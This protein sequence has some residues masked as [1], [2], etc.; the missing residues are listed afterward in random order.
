LYARH[1][2]AALA[3]AR[4]LAGSPEHSEDLVQEAFAAVL[5]AIRNGAGPQDS[6]RAYLVTAVRHQHY[7]TSKRARR[8][9][10]TADIE[11]LDRPADGLADP[12][13][14]AQSA[15]DSQLI[16]SA[17]RSLPARWQR[18]LWSTEVEEQSP[19]ELAGELGVSANSAAAL[20]YRARKALAQAYLKAHVDVGVPADC[21]PVAS[22]LAGWVRG[23]L[24]PRQAAAVTAHV[25]DCQSCEAISADLAVVNTSLRAVAPLLLVLPALAGYAAAGNAAASLGAGPPGSS[26]SPIGS[27]SARLGQLSTPARVGIAAGV[28]GPILVGAA[29]AVAVLLGESPQRPVAAAPAQSA[30]APTDEPFAPVVTATA[31][32]PLPAA[33]T[34]GSPPTLPAVVPPGPAAAP[35]L[36]PPTVVFSSA[37]TPVPLQVTVADEGS[38]QTFVLVDDLSGYAAP[39]LEISALPAGWRVAL[40]PSPG[41]TCVG[42]HC[43]LPTAGATAADVAVEFVPGN[44]AGTGTA[45]ISV[46]GS[47]SDPKPI[48]GYPVELAQ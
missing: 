19:Q 44:A 27:L 13:D 5:T 26:G 1:R 48:V 32:S 40:L 39:A 23:E 8:A 34:A 17:F 24:S 3:A 22:K 14:R 12:A 11:V 45:L 41:V 47:G 35:T 38:A 30:P 28:T 15:L 10:P 42:L 37:P 9:V 29:I 25:S 31:S 2:P 33:T 4:S 46:Y 43:S 6:F 18:V 21:R 7:R 36:P 20:A 16:L